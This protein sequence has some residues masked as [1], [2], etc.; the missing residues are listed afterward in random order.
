MLKMQDF[1]HLR[2]LPLI[3][4]LRHFWTKPWK[5][6]NVRIANQNSI[7]K[8]FVIYVLKAINSIVRSAVLLNMNMKLGKVKKKN[9]LCADHLLSTSRSKIMKRI[10]T[11]QL[12]LMISL[13]W[14]KHW[15]IV[16]VLILNVNFVKRLKFFIWNLN[17]SSKSR[18][19]FKRSTIMTIIKTFVRIAKESM[20][21]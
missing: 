1:I 9:A 15:L 5:P 17:T 19:S 12:K 11:K 3:L 6:S 10:W 20:T 21:W 2:I 14:T 13:S 8:T 18:I 7:S 4:I 16:M